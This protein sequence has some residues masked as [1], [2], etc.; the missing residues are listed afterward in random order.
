MFSVFG[1]VLPSAVAI[2]ISPVPIIAVILMLMSP[3]SVRLGSAFLLGWAIG[4]IASATVFALAAD[5]VP[6][7]GADDSQPVL[8][9]IQMVLGVALLLLGFRQWRSRPAPGESAELPAWMNRVDGMTVAMAAGAG[10]ALAALN[11]K[12]MLAAAAA[13][14]II[15]RAGLQAG[16]LVV[17]LGAF[18][19]IAAASVLVPVVITALVPGAAAGVLAGV[20]AWLTENNPVIMMVLFVVLGA[21]VLG[22]GIGSF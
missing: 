6:S 14:A 17:V 11:P 15:G 21:S 18:T 1:A 2:A 20:R 22:N 5:A 3:R 12:N 7:S 16:E 9:G 4:V 13:G 10:L 8:G 19:A